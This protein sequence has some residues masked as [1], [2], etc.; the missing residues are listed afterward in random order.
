MADDQQILS[1]VKLYNE[2]R[3]CFVADTVYNAITYFSDRLCISKLLKEF[4]V[5]A[6]GY[7]KYSTNGNL[8]KKRNSII[9]RDVERII[10]KSP[11]EIAE[12]LNLSYARVKRIIYDFDIR[13]VDV[14]KY[15]NGKWLLDHNYDVYIIEEPQSGYV[16]GL[17]DTVSQAYSSA[18]DKAAA[19][20]SIKEEP[21]FRTGKSKF[22]SCLNSE[23][24]QGENPSRFLIARYMYFYNNIRIEE[25]NTPQ[26]MWCGFYFCFLF[27]CVVLCFFFLPYFVG[28]QLFGLIVAQKAPVD[29]VI[30]LLRKIVNKN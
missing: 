7:R 13:N 17:G 28:F 27:C 9:A 30:T 20:M 10:D 24:L 16:L 25:R 22:F 11:L 5:S 4:H 18:L 3:D 12:I 19:M 26:Q 8:V 21:R 29:E 23:Y 1:Y 2:Y 6:T 14:K 15:K